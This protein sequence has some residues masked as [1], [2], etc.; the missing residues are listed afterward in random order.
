[1]DKAVFFIGK[2]RGKGLVLEKGLPYLEE[3]TFTLLRTE[4]AIIV[5]VQQFTKHGVSGAPLHAENGF[6]KILPAKSDESSGARPIEASFSHPFGL[7]EFE[8][9]TYTNERVTLEAS[10]P[11]HFQ[12]GATAKGKQ[13]TFFKREYWLNEKGNLCYKMF[14]GFDDNEPFEHLNGELEPSE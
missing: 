2:W 12:R 7:N 13:T 1:M 10:K 4:P 14:L 6:F 3:L 5:N 11:E 8:Y 9:G